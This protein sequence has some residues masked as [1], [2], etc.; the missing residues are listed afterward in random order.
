M[1]LT[2]VFLDAGP[3]SEIVRRPGQRPEADACRLWFSTLITSGVPVRVAE[4]TDY[5]VRRELIRSGK[6]SSIRRLDALLLSADRY[7]PISTEAMREAANL[8]ATARNSGLA[9]APP[10][11]LDGD[12]IFAAQVRSWAV[13]EGIPLSEVMIAT[14]NVTHISRYAPADLWTNIHI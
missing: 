6:Q 11:A 5:E 14:T 12:V 2:A 9:T 8:W 1:A 13:N 4:V 3:L 7:L 10:E